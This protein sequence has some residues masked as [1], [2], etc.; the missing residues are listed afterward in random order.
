[1]RK[2][3]RREMRTSP[4][5][6]TEG[7]KLELGNC[8]LTLA[9]AGGANQRYQ[10]AMVAAHKK[11]GRAAELDVMPD[12]VG[13]RIVYEIWAETVVKL[14]ETDVA[15]EGEAPDWK[16]GIDDGNGGLLPFTVENAIAFFTEVPDFFLEVKK[17]A[18]NAQFYR[19]SLL[20]DAVKN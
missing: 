12:E 11:H 4:Q 14:W 10:A 8:R 15:P 5:L 7:I 20:D 19:Q 3:I 16:P 17:T 2:S 6:E 1:M 18:E 13:R 9:R